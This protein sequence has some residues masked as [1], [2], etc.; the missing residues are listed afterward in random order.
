MVNDLDIDI[1]VELQV[2]YAVIY[3]FEKDIRIESSL[4]G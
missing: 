4:D 2:H 1:T 3:S